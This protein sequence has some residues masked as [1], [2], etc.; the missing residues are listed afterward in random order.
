MTNQNKNIHFNLNQFRKI[1]D[2]IY[3][4]EPILTHLIKNNK[5]FLLY[6][7]DTLEIKDVFLLFELEIF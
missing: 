5:H 1:E 2:I 7:V 6:L 4:D 3:L